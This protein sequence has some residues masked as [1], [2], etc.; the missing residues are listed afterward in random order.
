MQMFKTYLSAKMHQL[1]G[2]FEMTT[3]KLVDHLIL[4]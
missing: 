2:F 1:T 4:Q 3:S